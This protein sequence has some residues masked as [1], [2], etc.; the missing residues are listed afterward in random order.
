MTDAPDARSLRGILNAAEVAAD[1]E[2]WDV[3]IEACNCA[4]ARAMK[5]QSR[6]EADD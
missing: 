3:V 1:E 5:N 4:K 6:G 2:R